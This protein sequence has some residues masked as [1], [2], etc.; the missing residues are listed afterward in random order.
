MKKQNYARQRK[1]RRVAQ[2]KFYVIIAILGVAL[3]TG[4]FFIIK[5]VSEQPGTGKTPGES[6]AISP[7]DPASIPT[8]TVTATGEP[9]PTPA[10][11]VLVPTANDQTNPTLLGFETHIYVD[12]AAQANFTRDGSVSFASGETYSALSGITTFRGNNYRDTA[13]SFGN[14]T[15]SAE[16]LTLMDIDKTTGVIGSWSGNAYTGQPLIV[17]WPDATRKIMTSLYDQF[18]NSS[19]Y[20][21]DFTEAIIA[22]ADGSIYFMELSTGTRTRDP[23][24]VGAPILGTPSLDPRGYPILYVG[25]GLNATGSATE[26]NNMYFRAFS[27][28]DYSMLL[29]FGAQ[30]SDPT[31]YGK[32]QAYNAS[33]LIDAA[34]DTLVEPGEN[35]VLYTVKL[36]TNYDEAAGTLTMD[37][38]PTIKCT[39]STPRNQ[40]VTTY[41]IGSSPVGWSHYVF[42]TDNI[43]LLQCVDLNTMTLVYANDLGNDSRSTMVLEEDTASQRTYLYTGCAYD[44][45]AVQSQETQGTCFARRIDA[46]TGD[47][48]W[49]TP[50]TVYTDSNNEGGILAS[51][52][53]GKAGTTMD[54][55]VIYTVSNAVTSDSGPQGT[56][57]LVAL[58]KSSGNIVWQIDLYADDHAKAGW[59]PS[60]PAAVYT[61]D[62]KGYI[63]QCL[64][65]GTIRLIRVSGATADGAVVASSVNVNQNATEP[66]NFEATPAVF[67]NTIVVGSRSGHFFFLTI[68]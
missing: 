53:V 68:G 27:L 61:A 46:M 66:N 39:Y 40:Q 50:F 43:G 44:K 26:C 41:G 22:S 16:T 47:I 35:G 30:D 58:D 3:A 18:R 12:G 6:V 19:N 63:V 15:I 54:G 9:T 67:G 14:A 55:L 60:S 23:I 59:T 56:A 13:S 28:I 32:W 11:V 33:P 52:I 62:G 1:V 7:P 20:H 65:G 48:L 24:R 37:P 36:N 5:A 38:D 17:V 10:P 51:P 25:Q 45:D 29:K 64:A 49:A 2:T 42:F 21:D 8:E 34:T 31:A 4:I 57:L